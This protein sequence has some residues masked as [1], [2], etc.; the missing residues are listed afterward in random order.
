MRGADGQDWRVMVQAA[1]GDYFF[2]A[3]EEGIMKQVRKKYRRLGHEEATVWLAIVALRRQGH[4]IF[5]HGW[6]THMLDGRI[7]SSRQLLELAKKTA[8]GAYGDVNH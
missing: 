4:R 5:R 7:T 1:Y 6:G 8:I 2:R 3:D